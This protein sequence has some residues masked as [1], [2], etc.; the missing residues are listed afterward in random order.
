M[1]CI[2]SN[3][4]DKIKF[5]LLSLTWGLVLVMNAQTKLLANENSNVPTD[6]L[7]K[8]VLNSITIRN[9]KISRGNLEVYCK[10]F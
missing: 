2:L 4:A 10:H 6:V 7:F 8:G 5:T 1:S 9:S 3:R